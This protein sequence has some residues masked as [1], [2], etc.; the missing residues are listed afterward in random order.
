MNKLIK[1]LCLSIVLG[2]SVFAQTQTQT[3]EY[4]KN[5]YYFGYSNQQS[6]SFQRS[7]FHGVEGS[8]TRNVSR[9]FGIRGTISYAKSDRTF[10]GT[11]T[12]PVNG[13]YNF[14][15]TNSRSV[16]NFLGGIQVK[17]NAS[18]KRFKPFGYALGGVAVNRSTFKNLACA[19]Q[20]CPANVPLLNN[21]TFRDTGISGAFGGGLDIKITD[22]IDF[23][24]I[25]AD[26]N[27]IYS[28]ARV[29]N[30]FRF[31]VGIVFK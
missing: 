18:K 16:A 7:T 2:V 20:N 30:N 12:D 25:Q 15:Q 3:D 4:N 13:S 9:W 27:P 24:A 17:D 28:D 21:F 1:A 19:S 29:D 26:Y 31:G 5:E 8:Y 10:V 23:R 14:Q 22:K 11:V 6:G